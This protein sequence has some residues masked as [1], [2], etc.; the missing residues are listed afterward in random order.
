LEVAGACLPFVDAAEPGARRD[1][2]WCLPKVLGV[3]LAL[4]LALTLVL[5]RPPLA[6]VVVV[7]R[8]P[9]FV[10]WGGGGGGGSLFTRDDFLTPLSKTV[11]GP[12]AAKDFQGGEG[13]REDEERDVRSSSLRRFAGGPV[14]TLSSALGGA[15]VCSADGK[16]GWGVPSPLDSCWIWLWMA[17]D[18][19]SMLDGSAVAVGV[20]VEA[21]VGAGVACSSLSRRSSSTSITKSR[22]T[23][24]SPHNT[25][26]HL[27]P[28]QIDMNRVKCRV[29]AQLSIYQGRW[30]GQISSGWSRGRC[31]GQKCCRGRSC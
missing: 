25:G 11:V 13:A 6:V 8:A 30:R 4:V 14:R 5:V 1:G 21:G 26:D 10:G 2:G 31:I 3:P 23:A 22:R 9:R 16:A 15:G 28:P 12:S 7:V 18:A 20:D 29:V 19:S 27:A 17:S 24:G